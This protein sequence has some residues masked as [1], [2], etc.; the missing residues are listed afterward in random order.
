MHNALQMTKECVLREIEKINN[1]GEMTNA[2]LDN[3]MKATKV[4]VNI[5][6]IKGMEEYSDQNFYGYSKGVLPHYSEPRML[7]YGPHMGHMNMNPSYGGYYGDTRYEQGHSNHSIE[8]RMI[9]NL[10]QQMDMAKSD[11]ERQTIMREIQHIREQQN[12]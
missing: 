8:D 1:R 12:K 5:D 3:L 7:S 4:L 2:D 6:G 9:A 11:Y 10:E